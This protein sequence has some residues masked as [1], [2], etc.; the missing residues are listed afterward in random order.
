MMKTESVFGW[1]KK[2]WITLLI[3]V[4]PL[5]DIFAYWTRNPNGTFAGFFRLAVM[6][7]LPLYLLFTL[8]KK[9]KF[10]ISMAAIGLVSV[11]HVL[12]CLRL[13]YI[14]M[15]FD[16]NYIAR[17]AQM[18]VLAICFTYFIKDEQ[19]RSQAF[20]GLVI[21]AAIYFASIILAVITGTAVDTYGP[22]LGVSGWVIGDNRCANSVICV[23]LAV[24]ILYFSVRSENKFINCIIPP[25]IAFALIM[26]GTKA[27]YFSIFAVY[28]G[29][30]GFLFL[31]KFI[32][33]GKFRIRMISVLLLTAVISAAVYP[34][35]PRC[36][37]SLTQQ[38][39][40][41]F[42]QG[43]L[44]RIIKELGYDLDSMTTEEKLA[45]PVIVQVFG[46]YYYKLI[47][48]IIP[49]MFSRFTYDEICEQYDFCTDA[50]KLINVRLMKTT[51]A[52][53]V[54]KHCDT[55]THLVGYE[56]SDMWYNG[57]TDLENDWPAVYFYYGYVGFA[58]YAL[59]IL[60]F[61]Y[62][63]LKRLF[64][65][66][67][68]TYTLENFLLL[69]CFV[70][71]IGLA[72]FSGSVLRRPNVSVYMALIIGLIYYKTAVFKKDDSLR[73]EET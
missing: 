53:L 46:D 48:A 12:N 11:L 43:E 33:G 1:L 36:K 70:L 15:R 25:I 72:Q 56:P 27:C 24:I 57:G 66:F 63:I 20:R 52:A 5:L 2:H 16:L 64:S 26:N 34:I 28:V 8:K 10:I 69:L 40:S 50:N 60:Y 14:D 51:Y 32:H 41:A 45:D 22:G 42:Q 7:A 39:S 61:A 31:D 68:G 58:M 21:A 38:A 35:T 67:S 3:A 73:I 13:G 6:L 30:A 49:D 55:L 65:D 44:E 17:T 37:I 47:W 62:L 23:T 4:Q 71:H 59:F 29:F 18:P 9:T 19:T 54:W